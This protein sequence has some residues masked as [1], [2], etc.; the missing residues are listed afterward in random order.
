MAK[1]V[2]LVL[3]ALVLVPVMLAA[4][5]QADANTRSERVTSRANPSPPVA[6]MAPAPRPCA[7]SY[8]RVLDLQRTYLISC[9]TARTALNKWLEKDNCRLGGTCFIRLGRNRVLWKC[10]SYREGGKTYH[11]DCYWARNPRHDA[12]WRYRGR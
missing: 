7:E 8:A 1:N 11:A 5:A 3:C 9:R 2:L 12:I 10:S 6:H 4:S